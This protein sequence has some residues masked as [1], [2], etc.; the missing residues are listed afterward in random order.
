MPIREGIRLI[1]FGQYEIDLACDELRKNGRKIRRPAQA[2]EL[3]ELLLK[4]PGEVV[5][6]EQLNARLWTN[7]T[8]VEFD[9]GINSCIRRLRA[10]LNDSAEQPR[11]IETLPKRGYRFIFPCDLPQ[12]EEATSQAPRTAQ[13][14][15]ISKLGAGAMGVVYRATDT[16]LGRDVALKFPVESILSSPR[17]VDAFEREARAAAA[18]NHPNICTVHCVGEQDGLLFMA[19]EWLEGE[20]LEAVLSRRELSIEE[21]LAIASQIAAALDAAHSRGIVHGDIKPANFLS[22]TNR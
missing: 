6:R 15:I 10:A 22:V 20:T 14:R 2:I 16:W 18:L 12:R 13:Y 19:M 1:R 21:V 7:G 4:R 11:Y 8:I 17:I 3:L 5:T 9:R